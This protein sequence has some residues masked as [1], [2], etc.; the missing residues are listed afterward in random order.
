MKQLE[1]CGAGTNLKAGVGGTGSAQAP[2][3]FSVVP[4]HFVGSQNTI[5]RYGECFR[6]G[7]YSLASFYSVSPVPSH[8]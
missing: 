3:I 4:L 5:S 7:Q 6:D 2:E 1:R 8:L